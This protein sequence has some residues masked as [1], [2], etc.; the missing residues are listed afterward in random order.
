M[1][2]SSK[3]NIGLGIFIGGLVLE[4]LVLGVLFA[5]THVFDSI[6]ISF[7]TVPFA[8]IASGIRTLGL[9]GGVLSGLGAAI[10][11]LITCLPIAYAFST[12]GGKKSLSEKLGF[13]LLGAVL[14]GGTYIMVNPTKFLPAEFLSD[15]ILMRAVVCSMIWSTVILCIALWGIRLLRSGKAKGVMKGMKAVLVLLSV[16]FVAAAVL[17]FGAIAKT[18]SDAESGSADLQVAIWG[19]FKNAVPYILDTV[20]AVLLFR[21][22]TIYTS[23]EQQGLREAAK[24]VS[25]ASCIMLGVVLT[26]TV[27]FNIMQVLLM[28]NLRNVNVVTELPILSSAFVVIAVMFCRLIVENRDL[29]DDNELFV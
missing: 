6:S 19:A 12:L 2:R 28:K 11:A 22:I 15:K 24:S 20:I 4:A 3:S 23:E 14:G 26:L 16:I 1:T 13:I 25:R 17:S 29:R 5:C 10:L 9:K 7:M 27:V 8:Q 18:F 21:L